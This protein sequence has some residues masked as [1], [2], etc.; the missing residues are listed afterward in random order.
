MPFSYSKLRGRIVE[1]YRTNANFAEKLNISP[2]ALSKKL[3]CKTGLSQDDI[4]LWSSELDIKQEEY[5][6]YFFA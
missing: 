1:K 5:G 6:E 4:L 2:V 3:N